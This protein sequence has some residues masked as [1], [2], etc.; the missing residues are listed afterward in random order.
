MKR[1][2]TSIISLFLAVRHLKVF[3][4]TLVIISI[5]T[6]LVC[7]SNNDS[8]VLTERTKRIIDLYIENTN[9]KGCDICIETL[10]CN[11]KYTFSIFA[12]ELGG[13]GVLYGNYCG[14][15]MYRNHRIE[16]WGESGNGYFWKQKHK[17]MYVPEQESTCH[18][19]PCDWH[20]TINMS[21]ST[22]IEDSCHFTCGIDYPIDT[23]NTLLK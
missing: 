3:T 18:F 20:L 4:I 6:L 1:L 17:P 10:S 12:S 5:S 7:C 21:D 11:G 2:T 22:V 15:T 13:G 14:S 23:F 19:D 8:P 16:L 9:V